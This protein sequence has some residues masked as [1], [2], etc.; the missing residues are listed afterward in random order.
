MRSIPKGKRT[1]IIMISGV[2]KNALHQ[3]EAVQKHGA[4][5]FLEKPMRLSALY[6][7]LKAALGNKYPRPKSRR[8]A[9]A[10]GRRRPGHRRAPGRPRG[11][12]GARPGG[13]H[14]RD[15]DPKEALRPP[16]PP[17][18]SG[19]DADDAPT[20]SAMPQLDAPPT[21]DDDRPGPPLAS[22]PR[23]PTRQERLRPAPPPAARAARPPPPP[24]EEEP[25][26]GDFAERPFAEVLAELYRWQGLGRAAAAPREGEEDRLFPRGRAAVGEVATCSSSAW[27]G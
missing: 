18:P 10:A 22:P 9:A 7:T 25:E 8:A 3:K 13:E 14:R 4:F 19:P 21:E 17:P 2:Y 26:T 11:A 23:R 15:H 24:P 12:R 6:D 20:Q 27:G 16:P 5:A 1:P